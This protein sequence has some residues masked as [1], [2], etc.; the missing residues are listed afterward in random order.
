MKKI[1]CFTFFNELDLLEFR[2]TLLNEYIDHFIIVES[3]LSHAGKAK[4]YYFEESRDRFAKWENKITY[5]PL[6]QSTEGL[7][8]K[9]RT[10]HDLDDGSWILENQQRNAIKDVAVVNPGD[11]VFIGDLDEIPDPLTLKKML[12]LSQPKALSMRFHYYFMNCRNMGIEKY[13][14]GTVAVPGEYFNNYSPQYIRDN[15]NNYKAIENGG[16][17]FSYLGGVEKIKYKLQS[18]A[19]TEY[20]KEEFLND[21]YILLSLQ[22]GLDI[23]KRPDTKYKIFPLF[24]YPYRIR[25]LM[26]QYPNFIKNTTV[27]KW[28]LGYLR[29]PF[30]C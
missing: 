8:F 29:L 22:K 26:K 4:P 3:N 6:V 28:L 5:Y 1:D 12:S 24:F 30:L 27:M 18:F 23:L 20:N 16:W 17:H 7:V 19:H 15:R 21:D 25:K 10:A 11:L 9:E 14:K 2:L 13:W